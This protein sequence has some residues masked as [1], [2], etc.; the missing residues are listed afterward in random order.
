MSAQILSQEEVDALLRGVVGGEIETE[1]E[2][3]EVAAGAGPLP[4]DFGAQDK[5]IRGRMPTLDAIND[6]FARFFRNTV[7]NMLR[8]MVDVTPVSLDTLKFG[9][10]MRSLPVPSPYSEMNKSAARPS[11][12]K[13]LLVATSTR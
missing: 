8:R 5:V 3:P 13:A 4:Y 7:S 11:G 1:T 9:N 2:V 6:R 12:S 10:F